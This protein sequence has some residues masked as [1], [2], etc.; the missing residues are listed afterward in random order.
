MSLQYTYIYIST[1]IYLEYFKSIDASLHYGNC[2]TLLAEP[3]KCSNSS[4]RLFFAGMINMIDMKDIKDMMDMVDMMDMMEI[5]DM[6]NTVEMMDMVDLM[7]M[8]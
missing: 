6:L 5:M 2:W 4:L 8:M 3:R 7:D 1:G